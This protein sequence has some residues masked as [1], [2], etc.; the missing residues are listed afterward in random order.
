MIPGHCSGLW[1]EGVPQQMPGRL[2][3]AFCSIALLK[4]SIALKE[5]VVQEVPVLIDGDSAG[6]DNAMQGE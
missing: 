5:T 1:Q 2:L 6:G 3:C 4:E